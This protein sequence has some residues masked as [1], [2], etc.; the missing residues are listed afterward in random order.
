MAYSQYFESDEGFRSLAS[1]DS[2][3]NTKIRSTRFG[4]ATRPSRSPIP[5][6]KKAQSS[7]E[8]T[9]FCFF[10]DPAAPE[11]STRRRPGRPRPVTS[12][13]STASGCINLRGRDFDP[14]TETFL[15]PAEDLQ[16]LSGFDTFWYNW[17]L[18]HPGFTDPGPTPVKIADSSHPPSGWRCRLPQLQPGATHSP[19]RQRGVNVRPVEP[20]H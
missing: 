18:I 19:E 6:T 1:S 12:R 4:K 16:K 15:G 5:A 7:S 10:T 9:G 2:R 8:E 11:Y 17:S 14:S 13:R 3:L 20:K